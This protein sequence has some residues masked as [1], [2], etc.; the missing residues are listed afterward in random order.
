ML[1]LTVVP[2]GQPGVTLVD[3]TTAI[4]MLL[5]TSSKMT[6]S[7]IRVRVDARRLTLWVPSTS[8][9]PASSANGHDS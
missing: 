2:V 8:V 6:A 4:S 5:N 3:E 1:R 9:M 7:T